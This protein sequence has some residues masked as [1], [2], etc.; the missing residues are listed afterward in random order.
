MLTIHR[1][2]GGMGPKLGRWMAMAV[3]DGAKQRL[4]NYTVWL[5]ALWASALNLLNHHSYPLFTTEVG[6][7]LAGLAIV[8][9]LMG[10]LVQ[11][12]GTRIGF[13]F[14]SLFVAIA[15]DLNVPLS[16]INFYMLW[17]GLAVVAWFLE[18]PLLKLTMA[19]FGSVLAFQFIALTTGIGAHQRSEDETQVRQNTAVPAADR[20]PIVHLVLDSY[21]G[22]DGMA[23]GPA[24]VQRLRAE[25]A[26]FFARHGFQVYPK[27][28][29]RH[30]KTIN[31]LPHLF[32]YGKAPLATTPRNLQYYVPA[33]LDYFTDLDQRGYRIDALLPSYVDL[34]VKHPMTR[35]RN[36]ERS[37]LDS[38]R[39]TAIPASDRATVFAF[40]MLQLTALPSRAAEAMVLGAN[41]LFGLEARRPYDRPKLLPLVSLDRLEDFTA[42]LATLQRGEVRLAHLLAPHDPYMLDARCRALPGRQW[43]DEHGPGAVDARQAAYADQVRCLTSRIDR[44]M[45]ALEATPAGREA[46]VVIHGDHGSRITPVVP[47]LDGPELTDLEVLTSHATLFAIRVPG[48]N[49]ASID[50]AVSLDELMA[51]FRRREFASAPRPDASPAR[52]YLMDMQWIPREMR[53]LPDFAR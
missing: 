7:L 26:A 11:V 16:L 8:A 10:T 12:A 35:C 5:I 19:A 18:R 9:V 50:G 4:F 17:A 25:Q 34:C 49:A 43:L 6:L 33:P 47:F 42:D 22:L 3:S 36:Y 27:A 14:T 40:T 32:S 21:I 39:G 44:M 15:I 13:V 1:Y 29:S 48:E 53:D 38:M 28:Y 46:I 37:G 45:A 41:D 51:D 2:P 24:P 31:S 20:A 30:V 23:L 52:V